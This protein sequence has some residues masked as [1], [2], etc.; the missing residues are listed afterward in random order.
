MS[1]AAPAIDA[2]PATPRTDRVVTVASAVVAAG[3]LGLMGL[4]FVL[5]STWGP[6]LPAHPRTLLWHAAWLSLSV[7]TLV[8]TAVSDPRRLRTL[9]WPLFGALVLALALV[10]VPCIGARFHGAMRLLVMGPL[11]VEPAVWGPPALVILMAHLLAG[12]TGGKGPAPF[13]AGFA[14][15]A[16]AAGLA[17]TLIALEPSFT[18]AML[19]ALV[20][21]GML[22]LAGPRGPTMLAAA[23]FMTVISLQIAASPVRW[24]RVV[25]FFAGGDGRPKPCGGDTLLCGGWA[26]AGLGHGTLPAHFAPSEL[27]D[28][29]LGVLGGDLGLIAVLAV[30]G[31]LAAMLIAGVVIARRAP[32]R[33]GRL[34]A[35]GLVML[36][37]LQALI[38][39]AV[40]ARWLPLKSTAFPFL[41]FRGSSMLVPVV[42]AGLWLS[43]ARRGGM[44][45][46]TRG[47]EPA[48][49]G[50]GDAAI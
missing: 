23:A 15:P 1:G 29:A 11:I 28:F 22:M 17:M 7:M 3:A 32:D 27:Q 50:A 24:Q 14:I 21:F 33:F 16:A 36:L 49:P 2:H 35:A 42:C 4:G 5:H 19:A 41:D 37:G 26:G 8:M 48:A 43:V 12:R 25:A 45:V 39:V 6:D 38:H 31:V 30:I 44:P 10:L 20:A 46:R 34:L 18:T 9:A 47:P 40:V 13:L